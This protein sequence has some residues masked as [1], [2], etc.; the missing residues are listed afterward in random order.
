M[1]YIIFLF[2]IISCKQEDAKNTISQDGTIDIALVENIAVD[3]KT[4]KAKKIALEFTARLKSGEAL[5]SLFHDSWTLIYHEDD[6]CKGAT[7]GT[8]TFSKG[9]KIDS[10]LQLTVSNNTE[11]AWACEKKESYS[12]EMIFD[13]KEKVKVWDRFELASQDNADASEKEKNTFYISGAGDAAYI[14]IY[15]MDN[16]ISTLK[17]S[18][19][20]PG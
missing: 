11:F 10:A 19:E 18:S 13:L 1:K 6:R 4:E 7:D 17:Y 12:Y 5:A 2:L 9:Q 16:L 8:A 14:E 15:I 3:K 20:D